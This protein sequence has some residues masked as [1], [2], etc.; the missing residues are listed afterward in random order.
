M[1]RIT[2]SRSKHRCLYTHSSLSHS[3]HP[4]S[5]PQSCLKCIPQVPNLGRCTVVKYSWE[6]LFCLSGWQIVAHTSYRFYY[7]SVF[8][9]TIPSIW[10]A[11]WFN[12]FL[13]AK[14]L[15]HPSRLGSYAFCTMM[16]SWILAKFYRC[17]TSVL[18]H[19]LK[20]NNWLRATEKWLREGGGKDRLENGQ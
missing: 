11:L 8:T 1:L 9:H 16:A 17:L 15:T 19:L 5:V 6:T 20:E 13:P 3:P 10:T 4:H 14:V 2:T 12:P 18:R 7:F